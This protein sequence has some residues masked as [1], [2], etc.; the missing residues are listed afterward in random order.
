[1]RFAQF[2]VAEMDRIMEMWETYARSLPPGRA[3]TVARLRD[4]AERM[5]RFIARDMDT[6]QTSQEQFA[7]SIGAGPQPDIDDPS[8]AQDHGLSR[9]VDRFSLS[10]LVGEYRAL[11][12]SVLSLWL[13]SAEADRDIEQVIRFDEAVDQL[14]AESVERFSAK[15]ESDANTFTASIGHDLRNP[16]NAIS[17]CA[18]LL[19]VSATVSSQDRRA[20]EQIAQSAIRMAT[21]LGELQDFSRVRLGGMSAFTREDVDVARLCDEV[22]E[23]VRASYPD[24]RITCSHVGSAVARVSRERTGQLLSNLLGNAVQHGATDAAIDVTV[25]GRE[26]D[27]VITVHNMGVAIP[28][29]ALPHIFD[30]LFRTGPADQDNRQHLGLGL[31]IAKTI[32]IAHGGDIDVSST[33]DAGTTFRVRLP[34]DV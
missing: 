19:N 28:Q 2:I 30:P 31:Y 29:E 3:M 5:L 32:A 7:K 24:R 25:T 17:M 14:I 15:L 27:V 23:E 6:R 34:R 12:A 26:L 10:E 22:V 1:M 4:D 13:G 21:M 20:V 11:R 8:A 33:S 18:Q 9:A 16:L